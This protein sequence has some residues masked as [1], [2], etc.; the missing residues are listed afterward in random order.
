MKPGLY[1]ECCTKNVITK[2]NPGCNYALFSGTWNV[3]RKPT[4]NKTIFSQK[5][6]VFDLIIA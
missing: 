5:F 4:A 6:L 2:N 1:L 3:M